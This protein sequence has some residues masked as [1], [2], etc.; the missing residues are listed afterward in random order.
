MSDNHTHKGVVRS[1]TGKLRPHPVSRN[2]KDPTVQKW[3]NEELKKGSS[4]QPT[5]IRNMM[6]KVK[7][8]KSVGVTPKEKTIRLKVDNEGYITMDLDKAP[9]NG[10]KITFTRKEGRKKRTVGVKID[11]EPCTENGRNKTLVI[12]KIY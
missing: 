9:V 1:D 2:H 11:N 12:D 6:N 10:V 7:P 4:T 8:K 5:F 3:H